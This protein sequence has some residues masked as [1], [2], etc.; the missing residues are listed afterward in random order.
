MQIS[1]RI[2]E[3]QAPFTKQQVHDV[4]V[5]NNSDTY[6]AFKVKTT[7]PKLYCVRPNAS[8]IAPGVSI[9]VHIILQGLSEEPSVGT[10]CKDKFL[11]VS[12]PCDSSIDPKTV[13]QTWSSLQSAAGGNSTGLKMKVAFNYDNDIDAIG[14]ED[15]SAPSSEAKTTSAAVA[16]TAKTTASR[17]VKPTDKDVVAE[18][19]KPVKLEKSIKSEKEVENLPEEEEEEG[20]EKSAETEE[21]TQFNTTEPPAVRGKSSSSINP[22]IAL[23]LLVLIVYL[24]LRFIL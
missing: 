5:T 23:L 24:V 8:T 22:Y 1:P 4:T 2:L 13:S 9:K 6:V 16:E 7:A 10:K 15:E 12:V 11:F 20:E 14:E 3:F 18:E 21:K 17:H 19:A